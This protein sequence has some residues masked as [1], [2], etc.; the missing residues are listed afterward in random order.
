MTPPSEPDTQHMGLFWTLR[1]DGSLPAAAEPRVPAT[2]LRVGPEVAGELAAAMEFADPAPVLQRFRLGRHCY[3]GRSESRLV[4]YGWITFDEEL[5]GGL[6]L[7]VRLLPAE[8]YIWDCATLPGYRGQHLYPALLAHMQRELQHAGY[9]R[10]WIGMDAD[11]LASQAGVARAGFRHVIDILQ[12]CNTPA[13][14]FLARP[15]PGASQEDVQAARYALFGDRE[16]S[17]I[18]LSET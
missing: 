13:R 7:R 1:L 14:T 3:I 15:V 16:A 12:V 6:D 17:R 18:T 11:N 5:I 8:A 4:T 9:R 2:F 10:I